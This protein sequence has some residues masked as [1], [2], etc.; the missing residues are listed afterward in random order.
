[1]FACVLL[2]LGNTEQYLKKKAASFN[3]DA[4]EMQTQI[5]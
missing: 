5:H 1:M 2:T 4:S 3:T